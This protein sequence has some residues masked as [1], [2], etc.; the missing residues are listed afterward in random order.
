M[1][2][3]GELFRS[4]A[5]LVSLVFNILYFVLVIRIILSWVNADPYNEIVQVI[6][7]ITDPILA[8]FRRLPLQIGAMD[9]SPIVAFLVLSVLKNFMVNIL[10]HI[11]YRLG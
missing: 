9:F 3:L 2:I 1:F 8:P 11:A 6:Y 5:L 7:R 10:Y 4:L